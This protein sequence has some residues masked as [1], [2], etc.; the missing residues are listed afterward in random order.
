MND[1]SLVQASIAITSYR[2]LSPG[3]DSIGLRTNQL[4]VDNYDSP[5]AFKEVKEFIAASRINNWDISSILSMADYYTDSMLLTFE[6]SSAEGN[7]EGKCW[8]LPSTLPLNMS[9]E[10]ALKR[11][12]SVR[13]Y[14]GDSI[15]FAELGTIAE[16]SAGVT[17]VQNVPDASGKEHPISL[18]SYSSGGGLY[19]ASLY[20]VAISVTGLPSGV[21]RYD[22]NCRALISVYGSEIV[23]EVIEA[24][25]VS[26]EQLNL[27]NA[28]AVCMLVAAPLRSMRKYGTRGL[29][30]SLHEI[31][32]I[33][34]NIHLVSTALGIGSVDCSSFDDA[35]L[36]L[37]MGFRD[38]INLI[39]DLIILGI[40]A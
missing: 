14:T 10:N 12:R 21:Y 28:S 3:I 40:P 31:G 36:H 34:Q 15:S 25:S 20:L 6:K 30:F 23:G 11:R 5:T 38:D 24:I 29:R 17:A 19:P 16:A 2:V 27:A 9:L 8:K 39:A 32:A 26:D 7:Q 1:S 18:R 35:A 37:A 22:P 4:S 13:H 33:S